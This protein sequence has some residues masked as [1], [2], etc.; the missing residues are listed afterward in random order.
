[1]KFTLKR[2]CAKCP[3][4]TDVPGYLRRTRA[5]EIANGLIRGTFACHETVDYSGESD[6]R[7]TEKTHHCAG[8]LIM[9]EHMEEPSQMMR[10]AE[11]IGCYDRTRLDMKAPVF[12]TA[13]DFI[14][15]HGGS[16]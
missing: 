1:M 14:L 8:A 4:R 9:L 10:I 15:H 6:G 11:R 3:F 5:V 13:E 16:R 7:E 12:T 2:P